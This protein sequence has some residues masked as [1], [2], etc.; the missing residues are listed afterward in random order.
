MSEPNALALS[1]SQDSVV[2]YCL[3]NPGNTSKKDLDRT[4]HQGIFLIPYQS[5]AQFG[6]NLDVDVVV[7]N[8]HTGAVVRCL[9]TEKKI[10]GFALVQKHEG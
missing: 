10:R 4:Y 6:I 3:L 2:Q 1:G 7:L 8:E 9:H 5:Q